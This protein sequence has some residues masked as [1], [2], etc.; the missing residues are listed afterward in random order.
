MEAALLLGAAVLAGVEGALLLGASV[1]VP[2]EAVA[3][4]LVTVVMAIA[5]RSEML[6]CKHGRSARQSVCAASDHWQDGSSA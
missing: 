1:V 5:S 4:V 2:A 6:W 3:A